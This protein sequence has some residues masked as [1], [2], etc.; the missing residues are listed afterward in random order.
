MKELR[1]A[2]ALIDVLQRSNPSAL[3]DAIADAETQGRTGWKEPLRRSLRE[4]NS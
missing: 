3:D 2:E 1:Q 4:L